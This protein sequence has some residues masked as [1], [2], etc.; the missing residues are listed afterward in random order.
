MFKVFLFLL[1]LILFGCV[2][3]LS[4]AS[5]MSN[6]NSKLTKAGS[7]ASDRAVASYKKKRVNN[8]SAKIA[9]PPLPAAAAWMQCGCGMQCKSCGSTEILN[10]SK[11]AAQVDDEAD[12]AIGRKR[13]ADERWTKYNV[14]FTNYWKDCG[15]MFVEPN[16]YC[17]HV[18]G[19]DH[20]GKGE[21]LGVYRNRKA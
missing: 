21:H 15:K 12:I 10:V 6:I 13:S 3:M 4:I 1:L 5:N 19:I 2:T 16:N 11:M 14:R 20:R 9:K 18:L 17:K 8:F 7:Q